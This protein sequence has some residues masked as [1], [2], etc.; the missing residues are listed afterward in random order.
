[1]EFNQSKFTHFSTEAGKVCIL[2]CCFFIPFSTSMSGSTGILATVF[3]LL[4]G[5]FKLIPRHITTN[6]PLL[7]ALLLL[8]LLCIG[9]TYSPVPFGEAFSY[10]KKYR[11]LLYLAVV[12]AFVA[13]DK[14][15][16]DRA[17]YAFVG[18]CVT[19]MLI[20]YGIFSGLI[21]SERYGYSIVYHITHSFF[22]AILAFW[23]LQKTFDVPRYR[24]LW[25]A[26]FLLATVNLIFV[27]P[28][29]TGMLVNIVLLILLFVQ[30][31]SAKY[32]A[33]ALLI[34]LCFFTAAFYTSKNFSTRVEQ[35]V[36][37]IQNYHATKSRTSLGMRFDWWQNSIDLIKAKPLTGHGTGSFEKVQKDLI[38]G[39]KTKPSD[40]PHNEYLLLSVQVGLAGGLLFIAIL[41]SLFRRSFLLTGTNRYLL[42]G[43]VAAMATGCLMNSLLFDSLQG[44]FFAFLAASL[45]ANVPPQ[46]KP[47]KT[48]KKE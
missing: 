24:L 11:E 1:M 17:G 9:M 20:S 6:R 35:A 23:S 45:A 46:D 36:H 2:L 40:N 5:K 21:H 26:I 31:L 3:W 10:L 15:L 38:K 33:T 8:V 7:Y 18:G 37:E 13:G 12:T 41:A 42:Q 48:M 4:S 29:R 39:T 19:L 28:G 22:M 27:T 16:A 32:C 25:F 47:Y 14:R 43:V 44:H 34:A 30:R